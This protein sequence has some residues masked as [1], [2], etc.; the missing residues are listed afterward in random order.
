[1]VSRINKEKIWTPILFGILTLSVVSGTN[2]T[3]GHNFSTNESASFI[4]LVDLIKTRAQLVQDN[5]ASDNTSPAREH[6]TRAFELWNSKDPVNNKA[7]KDEIAERNQRIADELSTT[8]TALK[9]ASEA[10]SD[11]AT[12]TYIAQIVSDLDAILDEALTAR[13]DADVLSNST[14][15]AMAMLDILDGILT[16]YGDAYAVGFDMTNMSMMM[17]SEGSHSMDME[18]GMRS[19]GSMDM[20]AGNISTHGMKRGLQPMMGDTKM[21]M[22]I[23]METGNAS[24]S[25]H[26][27]TMSSDQRSE[28][29]SPADYQTAQALAVRAQ[30]IFEDQLSYSSSNTQS[31]DNI[32]SALQELVNTIDSK[33]TPMDVMMIVHTRIHPN[34]ITAF[35]L[36]LR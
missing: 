32:A 6:V 8:L 15:Q 31:L 2:L 1:M 14:I 9:T 13:I 34:F 12:G 7:W 5:I 10:A 25:M 26:S 22:K 29:V 23:G 36:Q 11:N 18:G 35:G 30:E 3:F 17:G 33:G 20:G 28:L 27:N 21:G 16:G 19:M 4:A 24:S